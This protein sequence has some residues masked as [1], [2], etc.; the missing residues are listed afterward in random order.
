MYETAGDKAAAADQ[1]E[2]LVKIDENNVTAVRHLSQL[3]FALGDKTRGLEALQLSFYIAPLDAAP[4]T[5]IGDIY[6]NDGKN[7]LAVNEFHLA[8]GLKPANL[9]EAQYNYAR[10]LLADGKQAEAKRAV[11][12]ALETAPGYEKAQELLLKLTGNK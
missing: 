7:D 10:A 3:R 9:S 5:E 2:A 12:Q 6:L 4:H 8:L 11:L 1:L